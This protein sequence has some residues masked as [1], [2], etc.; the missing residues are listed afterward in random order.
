MEPDGSGDGRFSAPVPGGRHCTAQSCLTQAHSSAMAGEGPPRVTNGDVEEALSK[1][2]IKRRIKAERL[3]AAKEAKQAAKRTEAPAATA[4]DEDDEEHM[5][6][7]QYFA[8]RLRAIEHHDT[9]VRLAV[10]GRGERRAARA[11][12]REPGG[13]GALASSIWS[14]SLLLR[15]GGRRR[16]SAGGGRRPAGHHRPLRRH[17]RVAS[18]RRYRRRARPSGP[19]QEGRT[20]PVCHRDGAAE[21]VSAHAAQGTSG[22]QRPGDAVSPALPRSDHERVGA[23]DVRTARR[24]DAHD[25]HRGRRCYR[26]T[27]RH[28]PQRAGH[29]D[30]HAHRTGAVSEAAGDRRA[31]AGVRAGAQFSQRGHRFD[32]Q[33]RVHRLRILRGV[34]G[35]QRPD[36]AD[37]GDAELDGEAADRRVRRSVS[38]GRIAGRGAN[39]GDRLYPAV[40]S[41]VDAGCA[42]PSARRGGAGATAG[43]RRAQQRCRAATAAAAVHPA[44]RGVPSAADH[45]APAGQAGGRAGGAALHLAHLPVRPPGGV[46]SAGQELCNAYTELNDP[47][48]QRERF[49]RSQRD[50]DTGD[51]E[52]M[53][54]DEDFCTALEYGLPPTAGWGIG[55][56]R[57][58]MLLA[59]HNNIKEVLLFPAMKP[60]MAVTAAS[61]VE[62]M[63]TVLQSGC[64]VAEVAAPRPSART[65]PAGACTPGASQ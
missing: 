11:A 36:A 6:S 25:E 47:L 52:A 38:S 4:P 34:L 35:L 15:S 40:P 10:C 48:V 24:G 56:D 57:L 60:R 32:A 7:Q 8:H 12:R 61:G 49:T 30:V 54:A 42:A 46:E 59:D 64:A 14:A 50:A 22:A 13:P 63:A 21:F 2:E 43:R 33:P 26:Q 55:I 31:G 18:T 39:G 41:A 29:S 23:G 5:T 51:E 65:A 27:V 9:D 16:E 20:E 19:H 58:V 53:V 37:R 3:A 44:G 1:N 28:T 45:R 17:P 62:D